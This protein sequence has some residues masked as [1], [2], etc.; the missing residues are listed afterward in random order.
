MGPESTIQ[1][2]RLIV[3]SYRD[4]TQDG[5]FPPVIINSINLKK[6]MDLVGGK[7]LAALAE[8]L[9][10]ELGRLARAGAEF[11]LIAANMPHIVFDDIQRQSPIPLISIVEAA[12]GQAEALGITRVGLFG[13]RP[14]MQADFFPK[15]FSKRGI[16]VVIPGTDDQDYIHDKY[17]NE[18]LQNVFLPETRQGL[19]AIVERMAEQDGVQGIILGGTEL[20]LLLSDDAHA[21]VPFL[22]TTKIHVQHAVA[23]MLS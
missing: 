12:C 14:T 6:I 16:V 22:N 15:V 13:T 3:A 7:D 20:P 18:L 5:S 8:Y 19:L 4:Q 17:V 11:G 21:G 10:D 9:L 23:Q 2:Y 1:Y